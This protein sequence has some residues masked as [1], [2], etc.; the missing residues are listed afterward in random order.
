MSLGVNVL[1]FYN[2]K[3]NLWKFKEKVDEGVF[4]WYSIFS[5]TFRIYNRRNDTTEELL[6]VTFDESIPKHVE[7]EV[8]DCACI[9]E[10][11]SLKDNQESDREQNENQ[12]TGEELVHDQIPYTAP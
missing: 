1:S 10:K 6:N 2:G 12:V 4:I 9:L 11:T 7:V 5:K 8:V 3:D